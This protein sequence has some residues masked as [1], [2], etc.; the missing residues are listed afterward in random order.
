ML[1]VAV[2]RSSQREARARILVNIALG[3][4]G[5]ERLSQ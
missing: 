5:R 1:A 4:C 2:A 3:V